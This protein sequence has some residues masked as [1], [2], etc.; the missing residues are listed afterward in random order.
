MRHF[1]GHQDDVSEDLLCSQ[2]QNDVY[3]NQLQKR[4]GKTRSKLLSCML[5]WWPS[6]HFS[7]YE[8]PYN[9]GI[10]QLLGKSCFFHT[11]QYSYQSEAA[12][13]TGCSGQREQ[14][15]LPWSE[16]FVA[17]GYSALSKRKKY[18][19]TGADT[20]AGELKDTDG[21]GGR[22]AQSSRGWYQLGKKEG[23][24]ACRHR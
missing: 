12:N 2:N 11:W 20:W 19:P 22:H 8:V 21:Q 17:E 16:T 3:S 23:R 5:W 9:H 1:P 10:L 15:V 6:A 4:N 13:L 7:H 18:R 24:K 14:F